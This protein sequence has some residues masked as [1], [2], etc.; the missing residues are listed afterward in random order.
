MPEAVPLPTLLSQ[1]VVA[2]TIE[3]DNTAEARITGAGRR[4]WM[5]SQALW[6][7]YLRFVGDDGLHARELRSRALVSAKSIR[8]RLAAFTRW[9]Y[10]TVDVDEVVRLAAAGRRARAVWLPLAAEVEGR[11]CDR[12]GGERVAE[13]HAALAPAAATATALPRALPV[14]GHGLSSEVVP[15]T[16]LPAAAD[17]A[18]ADLS[19]LLAR[20]LL[21]IT[22]AFERKSPLSL[23][24]CA[25][26]LRVLGE[27]PVRVRDLPRLTGGSKE[28]LAMIVGHLARTG[29][30]T[31][32]PDPGAARGKVVRLTGRGGA[33]K[34][35]SARRLAAV[36][37]GVRARLGAAAVDRLRRVL[38]AV[39][40]APAFAQGLVP[41]AGGWRGRPPYL[42]HTE[43]LI[44]DPRGALPHD[45]LVLHR[46]GFPD[47]S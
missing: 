47:G 12:L 41:P 20:A 10:V 46:G 19:V 1:A 23:P 37:E 24:M 45:P 27:D 33:A 44:A 2:F 31:V 8:S 15:G 18:T 17:D 43:R 11:W 13:L 29:L 34:E 38:E 6:A 3:F 26:G 14:V 39:I 21:M 16:E 36:E 28:A 22:L 30:V 9:R 40:D 5:V 7:N 25:D 32:G 4:P 42:A 35:A